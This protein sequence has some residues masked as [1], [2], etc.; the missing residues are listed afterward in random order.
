MIK[1]RP[2]AGDA[3]A[4][5]ALL[6][7]RAVRLAQASRFRSPR[8]RPRHEAADA[9]LSRP[10]RDR[11]RRPQRQ[12]RARRHPRDRV[13]RPD[14]AADRG[15]PPS[16]TAGAAD[17]A[18][19][20][21]ASS[22]WITRPRATTDDGAPT[23]PA[24]GR[25]PAADDRRRADPGA[26]GGRPE[27]VERFA[28]FFGYESREA[29]ARDLLGHLEIVQGHYGQAVRGRSDRHGETAAGRLTAPARRIRGCSIIWPTLGFEAR[30]GGQTVRAGS[31]A[32]IGRSASR[33][34][35]PPLSNS[36]PA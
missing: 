3:K 9:G 17:A 5:E 7:D 12:A 26:A 10:E 13:L 27:A 32:I 22:N 18:R 15:R 24:P 21:L 14:P 33:R 4:G 23:L 8:R 28:K 6:A 1:A 19:C 16:G 11:G 34:P 20:V 30:G 35:K 25:A 2:C 31:P 36:C 29:F